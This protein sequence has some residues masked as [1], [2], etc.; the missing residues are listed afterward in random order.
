MADEILSEP[1]ADDQHSTE[2]ADKASII[3]QN[4]PG[5][6]ESEV[7]HYEPEEHDDDINIDVSEHRETDSA[8]ANY[9]DKE[10]S[11]ATATPFLSLMF[12][13]QIAIQEASPMVLSPTDDEMYNV[14]NYSNAS[15]LDMEKVCEQAATEIKAAEMKQQMEDED[16]V[17]VDELE[18]I[19][20][21][22][23]QNTDEKRQQSRLAEDNR[24]DETTTQEIFHVDNFGHETRREI[25]L[26]LQGNI[27]VDGTVEGRPLSPS[28]YTLEDINDNEDG[29]HDRQ[30][31]SAD[32]LRRRS[33]D[34][35]SSASLEE[36]APSPSEYTLIT[37]SMEGS[38]EPDR[39][40]M[41]SIPDDVFA[42]PEPLAPTS[43]QDVNVYLEMQYAKRNGVELMLI[44]EPAEL[45][46]HYSGICVVK[47]GCLFS[48]A[49]F[50]FM[51]C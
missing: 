50:S 35:L 18:C 41:Q 7:K 42:I 28:E 16:Q 31:T 1:I 17:T 23:M 27:T 29:E 2:A 44:G 25:E 5:L 30:Q 22:E 48:F 21:V 12:A 19:A 13:P 10:L 46:E 45:D 8:E 14:G 24:T 38:L 4:L 34:S 3:P 37:D 51:L 40:T 47:F 43:E 20:D 11:P 15:E 33:F 36:R 39:P 49:D 26:D 9:H 6:S 32:A